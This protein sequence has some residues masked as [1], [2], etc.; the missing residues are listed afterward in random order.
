MPC[1]AFDFGQ[2]LFIHQA[3]VERV[4]LAARWGAVVGQGA[5]ITG[6]KNMV[7]YNQ[8]S[9]SGDKAPY[10][11]LTASMV[12][13]NTSDLNTDNARLTVKVSQY[14]FSSFSP[15]IA[16]SYSGAPIQ[17]SVPLGMFN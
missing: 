15:F 2:F 3:L 14:P 8:P 6:T 11:N 9:N 10:F 12:E 7:L 13:V 1:G 17:V 16:G 5:D 4:R